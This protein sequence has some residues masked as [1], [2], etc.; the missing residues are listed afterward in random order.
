MI[1]RVQDA[2]HRE[3]TPLQ[4]KGACYRFREQERND[5]YQKL[6]RRMENSQTSF[7]FCSDGNPVPFFRHSTANCCGADS[8]TRLI[9]DTKFKMGNQKVASYLYCE[10]IKNKTLS[11]GDLTHYFSLSDDVFYRCWSNGFLLNYIP[12]CRWEQSENKY[13][14]K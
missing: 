4:K 7:T 11:I 6:A 12:N 5:F 9:P 10:L 3:V 2:T 13:M 14:L 8:I 1:K